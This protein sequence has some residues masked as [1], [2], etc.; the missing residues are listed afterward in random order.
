MCMGR[1]SVSIFLG[2]LLFAAGIDANAQSSPS[3]FHWN[4]FKGARTQTAPHAR[5]VK[6]RIDAGPAWSLIRNDPHYA[7]STAKNGAYV[8][9]FAIEVPILKSASILAGMDFDKESFSFDSYFF[10]PGYSLLVNGETNY[11]HALDID[12]LQF[13]ILYKFCFPWETRYPHT[14]YATFGYVYRYMMYNNALVTNVSNGGFVWEGQNDLKP[15]YNFL[16]QQGCSI[17]EFSL[18][19][20][21]NFM[22]TG[23]AFFFE[24]EYK[25]CISPLI[26]SGNN[27][28]SNSVFFTLN[29][30]AIKLGLRL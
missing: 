10:A 18:G 1:K 12:E 25:Y 9:G 22:A 6:L 30:F 21:K 8:M 26:Y 17:I 2:I 27:A 15:Q 29:T 5:N 11:N 3:K 28:G 7:N 20:Q 24:L 14:G 19:Y 16:S 4:P 13:P 23:N